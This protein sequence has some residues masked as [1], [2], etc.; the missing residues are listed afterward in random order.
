[1]NNP[2]PD[3]SDTA[4]AFADSLR[5]TTLDPFRP[6]TWAPHATPSPEPDRPAD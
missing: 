6:N 2:A 1:M 5:P 4:K 3:E